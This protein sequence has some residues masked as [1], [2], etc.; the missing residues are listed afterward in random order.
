VTWHL[1]PEALTRY[2]GGTADVALAASVETHVLSCA[3]CRR[4]L[5]A[6][7]DVPAL[8]AVWSDVVERLDA[9]RRSVLERV[10]SRCGLGDG[11]ARL[12]AATPS[13][14]LSWLSAIGFTLL[15]AV[16]STDAGAADVRAFLGLVPLVPV[17]GV[18]TAY[19]RGVDPLFEITAA[20]PYSLVR[21]LLLR[22]ATVL[23][24]SGL[25]IALSVL[26]LPATSW[27]PLVVVVPALALTVLS[28]L[29]ATAIAPPTAATVVAI[30]WLTTVAATRRRIPVEA[31]TGTT[32]QL[33]LAALA[34]A[35]TVLLVARRDSIDL[36]SS[37]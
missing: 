13:L 19:G 23:V 32:G 14:R 16:L 36:G 3:E 17:V 29:L 9:P 33:V 2:A 28:L 34:V 8:D 1:A 37:A 18:A 5:N 7:A 31:L 25:L 26:A 6:Y 4:A 21:L 12:V 11:D 22:V 35:G 30:G 24:A 20:S 15:I 27:S 10:L